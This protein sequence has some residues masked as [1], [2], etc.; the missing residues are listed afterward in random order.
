MYSLPWNCRFRRQPTLTLYPVSS[1]LKPAIAILQLVYSSFMAYMQYEPLV[2]CQGLPSP[3][4][5]AIRISVHELRQFDGKLCSGKLHAGHGYS[6]CRACEKCNSPDFLPPLEYRF[7]TNRRNKT[8]TTRF[9]IATIS[10]FRFY[11]AITICGRRWPPNNP[12]DSQYSATTF[13]SKPT[14]MHSGGCAA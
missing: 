9:A 8:S 6:A 11:I 13:I 1:K 2:K 5:T 3:F 12:L 10:S 7:S 14:S 4:L